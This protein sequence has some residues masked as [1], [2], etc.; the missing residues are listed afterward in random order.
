MI[1]FKDKE[2][3]TYQELLPIANKAFMKECE[4]KAKGKLPIDYDTYI[5]NNVDI[6]KWLKRNGWKR[7]RKMIKGYSRY[8]YYK[9]TL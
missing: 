5:Y 1:Q 4:E 8:Y 2:L 3:Y 7:I 9:E 6:G